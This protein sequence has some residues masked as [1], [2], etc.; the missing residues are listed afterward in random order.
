MPGSGVDCMDWT[1]G[2]DR[3]VP[4]TY[5]AREPLTLILLPG[6]GL[7]ESSAG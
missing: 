3:G 1:L 7:L 6:T 4:Q 2:Q 5:L